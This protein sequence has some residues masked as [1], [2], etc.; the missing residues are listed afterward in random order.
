MKLDRLLGILTVLLQKDRIT[1]P[2]LATRFEVSR[3][4]I[5]RDID[6]LCIAGIPIVSYQGSGGGVSIA[7]GFKLEKG[8]L[9]KDELSAIITALKGLGSISDESVIERTLDKLHANSE[10]VVS[11]R[12]PIII[13]FAS[14][15][16]SQLTEKIAIIKQ[17]ILREQIIEFD[18]FYDK[19]DVHRRI[20]PYFVIFQWTAWY[21]FGFCLERDDFRLFKLA[22]LWNLRQCDE[23]YIQ[24]AIPPEK[25]DFS[26]GFPAEEKKLVA[27]FDPSVKYQL[28]GLL[29]N[30]HPPGNSLILP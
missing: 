9:T 24:R 29:K 26:K 2:E 22:R 4:T 6:T 13:D 16:K 5:G 10:V 27:L 12:E 7:E 21:V 8:V 20:E 28:M 3:R 14:H 23:Q 25:R 19:G 30:N 1:A 18:Y 17:A 15:F 11:M